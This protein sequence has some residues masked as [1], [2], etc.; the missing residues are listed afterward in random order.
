MPKEQHH[1]SSNETCV[2]S[3]RQREVKRAVLSRAANL[4]P[5]LLD[6]SI[7]VSESRV[8]CAVGELE[9]LP[10][11]CCPRAPPGGYLPVSSPSIY[12]ASVLPS[13]NYS[14]IHTFTLGC[15]NPTCTP[16]QASHD[17]WRRHLRYEVQQGDRQS[18][19]RYTADADMSNV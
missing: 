13:S 9:G 5:Y 15:N 3:C 10:L 17:I 4:W 7:E 2:Q 1:L 6:K 16:V 18:L 11:A 14:V 19:T 8:E 12:S